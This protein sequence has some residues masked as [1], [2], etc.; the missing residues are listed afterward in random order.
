MVPTFEAAELF[1]PLEIRGGNKRGSQMA[2][3]V[4]RRFVF[5]KSIIA[6]L[7]KQANSEA[8][9]NQRPPSRIEAVSGF[10]WKRFMA[11]AQQKPPTKAKRFGAIQAVSL[12]SR[13]DPPLPPHSFG[14]LWWF[15]DADAPI[16]E[17]QPYPVLVA[18][19]RKSI[20]EIDGEFIKTLQDA[21]KTLSAK[22][23]MGQMVYSGELELYSFTSWCGFPIYET[24]FG[25]GKP[26]WV[27]SP[28][29]P[30]KN[31]V[32]LLNTSDGEGIEAWVNLEENDMAGFETDLELLSYTSS[33]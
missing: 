7:R 29:R 10:L 4:T 13:M 5:N 14:N 9:L 30:Y 17:E 27:C 23:K 20:K 31:V 33:S 1:P 3:I 8:F 22:R 24:D 32:V 12:R 25:W 16:D 6:A 15:A 11:V 18:K 28:G 2:K 26:M 21:E 19:I